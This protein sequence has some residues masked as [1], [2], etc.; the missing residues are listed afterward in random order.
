MAFTYLN[1]RGQ[2]YYLC[3]TARKGGGTGYTFSRKPGAAP[4]EAVPEGFEIHEN[5]NGQV[6][7]RRKTPALIEDTERELVQK[8]LDG[9]GKDRFYE[10]EIKGP[11][12]IVHEAEPSFALYRELAPMMSAE[13]MRE[14][15]RKRATFRPVLRFELVDRERR[16]FRPERYCF[17]GSVDDWIPIGPPAPLKDLAAQYLKHLGRDTFFDLF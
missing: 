7:L 4:A 15:E 11:L 8:R 13:R 16:L 5:P 9:L 6:F 17:R 3:C 14:A 2:T 10:I 1:R 12:L